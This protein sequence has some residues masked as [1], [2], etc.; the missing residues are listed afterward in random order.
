MFDLRL[1]GVTLTGVP[2]AEV[3][4]R[5]GPWIAASFVLMV[6]TGALLFY[7]IP[8]RSYQSLWF[9]IK[10]VALDPCGPERLRVSFR[11][12]ST[13][14]RVGPPARAAAGRW[15]CLTQPP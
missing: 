14:C 9:R 3:R 2:M 11:N 6:T 8:V 15:R 5:L 13:P 1:L 12:R 7:A 4:Q 10:V